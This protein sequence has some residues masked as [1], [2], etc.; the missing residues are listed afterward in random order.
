MTLEA[1]QQ[2]SK[3]QEDLLHEQQIAVS[4]SAQPFGACS[5]ETQIKKLLTGDAFSHYQ[6]DLIQPPIKKK[7]SMKVKKFKGCKIH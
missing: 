7:K 4:P 6:H 2:H 5:I 1:E 3:Q